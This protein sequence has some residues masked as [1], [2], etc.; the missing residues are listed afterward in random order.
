MKVLI[1]GAGR[2]AHELLGRIGE[3]WEV[4]II[5]PQASQDDILRD[6]PSV[7]KAVAGDASSPVVLKKA[8]ID[9]QDYVVAVTGDDEVNLAVATQAKA[10]GVRHVVAMAYLPANAQAL[11]ETGAKVFDITTFVVRDVFHYLQHPRARVMPLGGGL[12]EVMEIEVAERHW[13]AGKAATVLNDERWR[14]TTIFRGKDMVMPG[15]GVRIRP[16]DLLVLVGRPDMFGPVCSL[17]D[18]TEPHFPLAYGQDVLLAV[19]EEGDEHLKAL[20]DE[21]M[22]L[23]Q[24]TQAKRM[25]ILTTRDPEDLGEDLELWSKSVDLDVIP[26]GERLFRQV[27]TVCA[28]RSVG[29]AILPWRESSFFQSLARRT[30]LRLAHDLPCPLLAARGTEPYTRILV[31]FSGS[32]MTV[33]ALETALDICR[34]L[35]AS[36]TVAVV[37]EAEFV[38]GAGDGDWV[39]KTLELARETARRQQAD[40]EE[41]VL[42][43]NP[44]KELT[45]LARD[46]SLMVVA[47]GDPSSGLLSPNVAELLLDRAPCSVLVVT[48]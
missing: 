22:H 2:I 45:T 30:L 3:L 43:G 35:G 16:G 6:F 18:C 24:H 32:D 47:S 44:V 31:P 25:D 36:L 17:L 40:P 8:G 10:R 48:K 1:C 15:P 41:K 5:D 38:H 12:G 13:L 4:T 37:R 39:E 33:L 21:A 26:L 46:Y 20:V 14:L 19:P 11:R 28:E 34:Q 23:I 9:E 7:R 27:E 29:V 42:E